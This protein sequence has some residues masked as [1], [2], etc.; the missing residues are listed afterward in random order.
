MPGGCECHGV[1]SEYRVLAGR[2]LPLTLV[3]STSPS[4]SPRPYSLSARVKLSALFST[5]L[6][7]PNVRPVTNPH[8]RELLTQNMC[9][10]TA[11]QYP[12]H[13]FLF[14]GVITTCMAK[15]SLSSP[16]NLQSQKPT[17]ASPFSKQIPSACLSTRG[18]AW[19]Q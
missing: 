10:G 1:V 14:L 17:P 11:L 15:F 16:C 13:G 18:D 7:D 5:Q 6:N 9:S 12:S 8:T 2:D 3:Q 4:K 19:S